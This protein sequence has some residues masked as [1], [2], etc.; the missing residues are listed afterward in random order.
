MVVL[1]PLNNEL[2]FVFPNNP[3]FVFPNNPVFALLF[4]FP[5]NPVFALF[6]EVLLNIEVLLLP[7]RPPV[8]LFL[9][10]F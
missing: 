10:L 9:S 6:V 3:G 4:V 1:F 8:F 7:K 5:N 2:L